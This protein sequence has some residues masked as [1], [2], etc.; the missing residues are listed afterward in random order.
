MMHAFKVH[1][2]RQ[3][4]AFRFTGALTVSEGAEIFLDYVRTPAFDPRFAMLCDAREVTR[5]DAS[6]LSIFSRV[7]RL[8]PELARFREP[9]ISAVLVNNQTV[10]GY[11]RMLE[12][13]LD[14]T[15]VIRMRP[16]WSEDEAL[17]LTGQ[18]GT[19]FEALFQ[20]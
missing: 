3:L 8:A 15:S 10:F 20:P 6:F 9:V 14:T 17:A 11:V 13:I 1:P 2:A 18:S 12:Q 5:I 7:V 16:A 19:R 4:A